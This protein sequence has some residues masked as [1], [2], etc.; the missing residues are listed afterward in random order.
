MSFMIFSSA[1]KILKNVENDVHVDISVL[2][3]EVEF[4][5]MKSIRNGQCQLYNNMMIK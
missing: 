3:N 5:D 4:D 2:R 1:L